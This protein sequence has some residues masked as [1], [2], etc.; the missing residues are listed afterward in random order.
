MAVGSA[1]DECNGEMITKAET[2]K[3]IECSMDTMSAW[4]N[5]MRSHT[6]LTGIANVFEVYSHGQNQRNPQT[7]MACVKI[8]LRCMY[9]HL[10]LI[11]TSF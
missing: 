1:N 9:L 7:P 5:K 11:Q 8:N 10:P 6:D 4:Y 3:A 2:H